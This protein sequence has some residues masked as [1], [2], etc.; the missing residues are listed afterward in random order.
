MENGQL[1]CIANFIWGIADDILR[2]LYVPGKYRDV[3]LPMTV[4]RRLDACLEP[5]KP[6][7]LKMSEQI[8]KAGVANKNAALCQVAGPDANHAFYNDS[9]FMRRYLQART[10]PPFSGLLKIYSVSS[11]AEEAFQ[12]LTHSG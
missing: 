11:L 12:P 4:I 6:N 3:I 10:R 9:R 1:N 7:V 2:D 5:T 8:N